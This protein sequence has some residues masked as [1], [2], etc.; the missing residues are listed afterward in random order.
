MTTQN[1]HYVARHMTKPW[2]FGQRKLWVSDF[3]E[4]S[5][6]VVSSKKLLTTETPWDDSVEHFLN[7]YLESLF[8]AF[9]LGSTRRA[10]AATSPSES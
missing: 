9:W 1:S 5:F 3:Q 7:R 2:E 8:R 4:D 6:D 10:M